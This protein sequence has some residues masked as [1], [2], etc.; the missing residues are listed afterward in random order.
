MSVTN[1]SRCG[2]QTFLWRNVCT[3]YIQKRA[4]IISYWRNICTSIHAKMAAEQYSLDVLQT[5][6]CQLS[7]AIQN[8]PP[9]LLEKIY[10]EYVA[11]KMRERKEM[12]WNEVH[13]EIKEMPFCQ[14]RLRITK[15]MF[16]CN[17]TLCSINGLCYECCK[18]RE[19]RYLGYPYPAYGTYKENFQK[20]YWA[21]AILT[22]ALSLSKNRWLCST[23]LPSRVTLCD[24]VS[25]VSI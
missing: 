1:I 19:N 15:V 8:L 10:K 7:E 21:A 20:F 23:A 5:S 2:T 6:N 4:R 22:F 12:G 17:C 11:I 9:K 14:K 24:W 16:C 3:D 18:N 13:D 25:V